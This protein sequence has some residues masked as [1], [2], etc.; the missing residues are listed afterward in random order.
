VNTATT[1]IRCFVHAKEGFKEGVAAMKF[2]DGKA[3]QVMSD[4]A[5]VYNE[6]Y[7]LHTAEEMVR[8]GEWEEVQPGTVG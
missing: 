2:V 4:G 8:Q 7:R 6:A 3:Y 5:E 1:R